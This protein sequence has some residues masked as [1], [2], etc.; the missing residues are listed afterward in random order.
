[1]S[2]TLTSPTRADPHIQVTFREFERRLADHGHRPSEIHEL[3]RELVGVEPA[4]P[5][6]AERSLGLGP[7]IAVYL[8][9]LFIV[10]AI[11]SLLALYWDTLDP[12]GV[13]VV[14]MAS[15]AVF[16]VASEVSRRM[17]SS[18]PAAVLETVAVGFVPVIAYAIEKAA[19]YWPD[20]TED[21]RYIFNAV[22][23]MIA[24]GVAVAIGLLLIRPV[25]FLLVPLAAGMAVLGAD[26]TEA[27]FGNA[28]SE[29]ERFALL[30]PLGIAWIV[31]GLWLDVIRRRDYATWAH[32]AGLLT[33]GFSLMMLVP[34][35]VP[36]F[37]VIGTLGA[38]AMFFSAFVRHWSFTIVGAIGVL[39]AITGGLE[40]LGNAAPIAAAALGLALVAVGLR[41]SHW[42]DAL[43]GAVLERLPS[44]ARRIVSRLAP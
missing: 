8:G 5:E 35:T 10:A 30:L 25:P 44:D 15:F 13:L 38:I 32:L 43:R 19:G 17:L 26:L 31:V 41:W 18:Q 24:A 28:L 14:G 27:I 40:M 21:L 22:T 20:S 7:L 3:W 36:G 23:V 34:K 29:H 9:V 4:P 37:A 6:G 42:R 33:G 11:G 2:P 16:L 1:M 39:V 12:W